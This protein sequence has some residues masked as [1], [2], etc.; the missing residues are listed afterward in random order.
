[1]GLEGFEGSGQ[2]QL[3]YVR[4]KGAKEGKRAVYRA[5]K[6]IGYGIL[7]SIMAEFDQKKGPKG[8]K[9]AILGS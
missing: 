9:R 4:P 7:T 2:V 5:P 8:S 3:G 1:V 6:G